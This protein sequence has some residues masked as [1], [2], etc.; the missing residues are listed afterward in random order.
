MIILLAATTLLVSC[1]KEKNKDGIYKGS[2]VSVHEGK[3]W[4]AVKLNEEG[5][6]E[7]FSLVLT[8]AVLNSV[9]VG[10]PPPP[11]GGH[12]HSNEFII[13]I[14]K[15]AAQATPFQFLMLNWNPNGHEPAGVYDSAHFDIHFYMNPRSEVESF[16]DMAKIDQALPGP[17]YLPAQH[18]PGPGVPKMGKHWIDI[19]S[20]EFN[21][22]Q[23]SQ[24]F[25]YGSYDSKIVFYEPM[26]TLKFLKN[27]FTFERPIPQPARFAETGYYPTKMK[28]RKHDGVTEITLD[29]FVLRQAS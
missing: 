10:T 4:S 3:S 8:D 28:V 6:P 9:P 16:T 20:P 1:G 22:Q 14:H 26:I 18:V 21:G 13:P 11:G 27:T 2:E 25:I 29:G 24:T 17:D 19:G 12:D 7:Q 5:A 15:K 23:F